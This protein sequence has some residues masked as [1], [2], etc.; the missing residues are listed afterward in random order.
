MCLSNL[1]QWSLVC[2]GSATDKRGRLPY[3]YGHRLTNT[4]TGHP[5]FING[6]KNTSDQ[7]VVRHGTSWET[8]EDYGLQEG[9]TWCPS[10][11]W[12]TWPARTAWRIDTEASLWGVRMMTTYQ[13]LP[14]LQ[15]RLKNLGGWHSYSGWT[16]D[17]APAQSL[18]DADLP[19]RVLAADAVYWGGG[20]AW[21]WGDTRRINHVTSDPRRPAWQSLLRADGSAH[22]DGGSYDGDELNTQN[23]PNHNWSFKHALNGAFFYWQGNKP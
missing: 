19:R 17:A 18:R 10:A 16:S 9:V 20:P 15:E 4:N 7:D 11:I 22:G 8:L 14:N 2:V 5:S 3:P 12:P 23:P 1:R 21:P 13:F 6:Q